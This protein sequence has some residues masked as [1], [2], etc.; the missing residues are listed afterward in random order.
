MIRRGTFS[1][2]VKT[3]FAAADR[4]EASRCHRDVDAVP[5][6]GN[7][8]A[9]S[10]YERSKAQLGNLRLARFTALAIP[11]ASIAYA[12]TEL[13]QHQIATESFLVGFVPLL[14]SLFF[15]N[16][17]LL[18]LVFPPY[19]S[20][21]AESRLLVDKMNAIKENVRR[22]YAAYPPRTKG[23]LFKTA[24]S[25]NGKSIDEFETALAIGMR[26]EDKEVYVTAF[27]RAGIVLRVTAS[28]GSKYRCKP[29]DDVHLWSGHV[30]RLGCDEIRQ[31][32]SHPVF[33]GETS[34]SKQDYVSTQYLDSI[35]GPHSAL[36]R[37]LLVFWN[38]IDEWKIIEYDIRATYWLSAYFDAA[39]GRCYRI[40]E[41][42][43]NHG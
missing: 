13:L 5:A 20:W 15:V 21:L 37:H 34:P 27:V 11:S 38:D 33:D 18:G 4:Q 35:L 31:Y 29:A 10:T 24:Y 26:R 16:H 41:S 17:L 23:Q 12:A 39:A 22:L 3:P 28:I 42:S 14:L 30:T 1:E 19:R 36:V 43:P 40:A 6:L 8:D 7:M 9:A 32:H 2:E 25:L